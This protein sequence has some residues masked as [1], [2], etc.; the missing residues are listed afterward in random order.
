MGILAYRGQVTQALPGQTNRLVGTIGDK[1]VLG[2]YVKVNEWN[3]YEIIARGPVERFR[4][5]GTVKFAGVS[6]LGGA[7][8]SVFTLPEAQRIFHKQ[9]R[10]D[11]INAFEKHLA[12]RKTLTKKV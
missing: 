8:I 12:H 10:Y 9:G 4:I 6:S 2:G 1:Q 11:Q 3:D 5:V 7:T